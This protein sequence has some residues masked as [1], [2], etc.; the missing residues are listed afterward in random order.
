MVRK[1]ALQRGHRFF[2]LILLPERKRAVDHDY[3]NDR[4]GE[5]GHALPGHPPVRNQGE[6]RRHPQENGEEMCELPDEANRYGRLGK[7]LDAVGPEL[8]PPFRSFFRREALRRTAKRCKDHVQRE[9]VNQ[10]RR[11]PGWRLTGY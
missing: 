2:R 8:D 1:Q 10:H 6:E 5:R 4:D 11:Y 7:S 9:L 3:G